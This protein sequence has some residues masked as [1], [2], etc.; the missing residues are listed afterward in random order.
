MTVSTSTTKPATKY[1]VAIRDQAV[2]NGWVFTPL[3][4]AIDRFEKGN[5]VIDVTHGPSDLITTAEKVDGKSHV[6]VPKK[7]K[8]FVVQEWITG[9]ADPDQERFIRLTPEQIRQYESG[10]GIAKVRLNLADKVAEV[11]A[12]PKA[13]STPAPAKAPVKAQD[14]KPAAKP[15]PKAPAKAPAVTA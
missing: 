11:D 10:Q 7:G 4:E 12:K 8:M 14:P 2:N 6:K 5:V 15:V 9:I 13:K 1:R 3:G